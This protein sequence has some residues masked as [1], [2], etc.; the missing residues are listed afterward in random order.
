MEEL[1]HRFA[2]SSSDSEE[3]IGESNGLVLTVKLP[4]FVL[5]ETRRA[6]VGNI[7][8][9]NIIVVLERSA[10]EIRNIIVSCMF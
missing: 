6:F 8:K 10:I 4:C 7:D 1:T 9:K 2:V 3:D 5:E